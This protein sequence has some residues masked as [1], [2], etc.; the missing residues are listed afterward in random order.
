MEGDK[1][2][3]AR[4]SW[5]E[6]SETS[7]NQRPSWQAMS[8]KHTQTVARALYAIQNVPHSF[9]VNV[10]DAVEQLPEKRELADPLTVEEVIEAI[11]KL[12]AGKAGEKNGILPEDGEGTWRRNDRSHC[13][14]VPHC[15]E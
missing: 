14:P 1:R 3:T 8:E 6:T 7:C 12:K 9:D 5:L 2:N 4:K 15:M 11:W 10:I 13:K